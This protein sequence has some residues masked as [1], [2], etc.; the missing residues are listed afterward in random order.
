[1][2]TKFEWKDTNWD[3]PVKL[4]HIKINLREQIVKMR[5]G[6][7]WGRVVVFVIMVIDLRIS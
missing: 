1:M 6:S 4:D 3:T 5:S 7:R 2:H